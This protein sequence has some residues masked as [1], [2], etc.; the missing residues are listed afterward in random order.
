MIEIHSLSLDEF[1]Q[2]LENLIKIYL[3]AYKDLKAY[4]YT[5]RRNVKSYLKWLYKSDPESFFIAISDKKIIGFVA[6]TR[7]WWDK[8]YGEIGEVHEIVVDKPYQG[9]GIGKMLMERILFFLQKYHDTIGL[10]VGEKNQRAI[11]FYQHLGFN[12]VGQVGRW[13][14]MIKEK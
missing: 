6:G 4:A 1:K 2:N 7:F 13:L 5:H 10:W 9:K 8:T 14:R 11:A 12:I 3:N